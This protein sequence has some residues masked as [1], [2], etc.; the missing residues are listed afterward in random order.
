[1]RIRHEI[2][3]CL[4]L[5]LLAVGTSLAWGEGPLTWSFGAGES[6][7]CPKSI[8][9][10]GAKI[11][12]DLSALP[13]G[14]EPFRAVLSCQRES[15]LG[16]GRETDAA[17]VVPAG[18][19]KPLSLLPPRFG[20]FDATEPVA[21]AIRRGTSR[22]EFTVKGLTGWKRETTRL[23]V[24]FSGGTP[25]Q[26]IPAAVELRARHRSGQTILTWKEVDPPTTAAEMTIQQWRKLNKKLAAES[27][28]TT[29]RI[30]RHS[31][32]LTELT[33]EKAEL[34]DEV[35]PL[36]CWNAEF[37]GIYPEAND[38]VFRYVVDAAPEAGRSPP[39]AP[40]APGTGIYAHNPARAG[41]AYYYVST[42]INGE[43][44]FAALVKDLDGLRQAAVEET[45][46][47]GEPIVQRIE[48]SKEFFYLQGVT[49]CFYTRWEA[50]PCCNLPSRPYDY[51]VILGPK[52]ARPA[53]LN[54]I[55]HCWGSN[56]VGKGGAFSW[57]RW[58]D[59]AVGIGVA[60]NQIPYD[61]WTTYHENLGTWKSWND[62]VTRDFTAKRLLAFVDWVGTKWEVDKTR[63]CVSGE[64]MGGSGSTFLPIRYPDRFAN[65]FSSVGI[66][67]PASI[68]P[69]GFYES[70][71]NHNGE[72][73]AGLKHE[74]GLP[75]WDYLNDP[76]LVRKNPAARLPFIGFG[77][78]KNDGGIGW[79]HVVDLARAL[80]EARQPHALVWR[81]AGHSSGTFYPRDIDIRLDQ[82]LPAFTG[83]SLDDDIGTAKRRQTPKQFINR[84]KEVLKDVW[85]GDSE[86]QIN[87][88]LRWSTADIVDEPGKWECTV[89]LE[90][91][92]P[93]DECTVNI[94]PRRLQKLQVEPGRKFQWTARRV[95]GG[96]PQSGTAIA[97]KDALLTLPKVT[98]GKDGTR[99]ILKGE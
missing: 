7:T 98:V 24:W 99:L 9:F 37:N 44:D 16:R 78:G 1:M 74:S 4:L 71:A 59:Q 89:L 95:K 83:C 72:L 39:A 28:R 34:V 14:V 2:I 96:K 5:G 94:T 85:D 10:E 62:G 47:A 20:S 57:F 52:L 55:L 65:A 43:E 11:M 18:G 63:V 6:A 40:V 26:K 38:K 53:P 97:D 86:G 87:T 54:L 79:L 3:A 30:Y 29:Y 68:K 51:I 81:M 82:S 48:P 90:P 76:L 42:T 36:T 41:K 73:E 67:N 50:P 46:G 93:K 13:K 17:V 25:V 19:E 33:F 35:G 56:L 80:Q 58:K 22:V 91:K 64:S 21:R 45:V 31:E 70:Y 15:A 77:N 12:V 27:R 66:H 61:W 92:A 88:F 23:D 8:T 69:G 32:P 60:S 75:A 84:E 49:L